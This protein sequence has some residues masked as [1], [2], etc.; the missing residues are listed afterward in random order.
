MEEL[1]ATK[2]FIPSIRSE[3]VSRSRLIEQLNNGLH[4]RLTLISAPAGFGKTT[5]VSDWI[6]KFREEAKKESQADYKNAWLSL[7]E[8][9]NDLSRFLAYLIAALNHI[10]GTEVNFGKGVTGMLQSS[11]PPPLETALTSLINEIAEIPDKIIFILDDCHLINAQPVYEALNF[12]LE[13]MPPNLHLVIATREDPLLPLSRWRARCQ[14]TELR[15]VDLRFTNSEAAE[16]L[17]L[18]MG[19]NLSAQDVAALERR[20]E[21]WIAGLQ[22]AAISLHGKKDST[23]L[24]KSFSGSHR[25]VLD[26]LIEEVLEQQPE[27]V[28][29]FL[30]QTSILNQLTESLCDAL[31]GQENSQQVLESLERANLFII[32]LDEQRR[33]YRYHHLFADLLR[34]RLHQKHPEQIS[35]LHRLAS[36]WYEQKSLWSDAIHHAFASE[37]LERVADLI[38]LVWVPMNTNYQSVTWWRTWCARTAKST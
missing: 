7:D 24:I 31:T 25:L 34:Q 36:E 9:D 11:Q 22:M 14:M 16:F 6:S 32:P 35:K 20:T 23:G 3:L 17:N 33:W 28:Q 18:I 12:L 21:G 19:L 30:L 13:N 4:C 5:L 26:Y 29:N 27:S 1:L 8:G 15:A 10:K 37:D 2:L 38:E